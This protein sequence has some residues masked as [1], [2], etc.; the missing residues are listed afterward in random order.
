MSASPNLQSAIYNLQSAL[1]GEVHLWLIDLA[2]AADNLGALA[3]TLSPDERARA[4]RLRVPLARERFV[5]ARGALRA[6][7]ARYAGVAPAALRFRYGP[8]GKPYLDGP[9]SDAISFNLAHSDHLALLAVSSGSARVGVDIEIVGDADHEMIASRFFAP[10]E[11]RALDE[12]P[13][14]QR[15][16]AFYRCWVCKEAFVKARGE[17]LALALDQFTVDVAPS[18]PAALLHID[19]DPD[20]AGRWRLA[21]LTPAEGFV[22]ALCLE[23]RE[24]SESTEQ[25]SH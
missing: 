22:A 6:S 11:R 24:Q 18:A 14:D 1:G 8:A 4:E 2:A 25:M 19:G 20:E 3:Q 17:G 23:R 9:L 15:R 5:A 16:D 10:A 21:A 12:L 13:P 7:L